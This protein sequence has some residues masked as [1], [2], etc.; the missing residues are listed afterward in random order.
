MAQPSYAARELGGTV[1]KAA[2]AVKTKPKVQVKT[3]PL[4]IKQQALQQVNAVNAAS[5]A[6]TNQAAARAMKDA[7]LQAQQALGFQKALADINQGD[8]GRIY[9]AYGNAADKVSAYGNLAL[10]STGDSSRSAAAQAQNYL[11]SVGPDV[12]AETR[13]D[14]AGALRALGATA[15]GDAAGALR[16]E[17][18]FA[19]ER[20]QSVRDAQLMRLADIGANASYQGVQTANQLR[21]DEI[22]RASGAR[23]ADVNA[24]IT[25]LRTEGRAQRAEGR[26][27][28][29]ETRAATLATNT[30]ARAKAAELRASDDQRMKN[31]AFKIELQ[32][33]NVELAATKLANAT[34]EIARKKAQFELDNAGKLLDASLAQADA[35]L[36]STKAETA[37]TEA[38]TA[39]GGKTK[40]SLT[41]YQKSQAIAKAHDA[42]AEFY[43]PPPPDNPF[44]GEQKPRMSYPDALARL[45]GKFGLT[46]AQAVDVLNTYYTEAGADGRPVF[47]DQERGQLLKLGFTA[48]QIQQAMAGYAKTKKSGS[49]TPGYKLYEKMYDRLAA[50]GMPAPTK[51]TW[52]LTGPTG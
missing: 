45:R 25:A 5:M 32:Q 44:A 11:A 36:A 7:K 43:D 48:A 31:L 8:A 40:P 39:A 13:P 22:A 1:K 38:D 15:V 24:A 26:E 17:G 52:G 47:S 27:A 41:P 30:E 28:R 9:D 29:A 3:K 19:Q 21:S 34:G 20:Q 49:S 51:P 37:A 35:D 33:K 6:T 50:P 4:T 10:A 23:A 2:A 12:G 18:A 16:G 42:A 46:R 14:I